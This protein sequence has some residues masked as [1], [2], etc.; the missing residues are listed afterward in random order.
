MKLF[1]VIVFNNS[2]ISKRSYYNP[3]GR[4]CPKFSELALVN[5]YHK[6]NEEVLLTIYMMNF[7]RETPKK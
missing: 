1:N 5:H 3:Y 2:H 4:E 7:N 6:I